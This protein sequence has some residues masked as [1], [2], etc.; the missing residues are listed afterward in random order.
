M[1]NSRE[2]I[3]TDARVYKVNALL[4]AK[5]R[6]EVYNAHCTILPNF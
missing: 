4:K 2:K 3:H 5:E 1:E 6:D